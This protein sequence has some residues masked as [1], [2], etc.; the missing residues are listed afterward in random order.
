MSTAE[1]Q[2]VNT[3]FLIFKINKGTIKNSLLKNHSTKI[4]NYS[5]F[6]LLIGFDFY[7]PGAGVW[8][9]INLF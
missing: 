1:Y 7:F 8:E 4:I 6:P 2:I 9:K 5:K 3:R